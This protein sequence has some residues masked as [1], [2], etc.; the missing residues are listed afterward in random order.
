MSSKSLKLMTEDIVISGMS[1]RFPE[2]DTT[3]EFAHN[4]YTGVDMITEESRRWPKGMST[5]KVK[6]KQNF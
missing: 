5:K 1:G 4:L 2:S 3:D 6:N